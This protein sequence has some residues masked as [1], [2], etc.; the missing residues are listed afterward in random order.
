MYPRVETPGRVSTLGTCA[1]ISTTL[2][3]VASSTLA[4][5]ISSCVAILRV[6][7]NDQPSHLPIAG[8][9][10]KTR[11]AWTDSSPNK[12]NCHWQAHS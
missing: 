11:T 6:L 1:N 5:L 2:K 3:V 8:A 10:D 4:G 7:S 9:A 12:S